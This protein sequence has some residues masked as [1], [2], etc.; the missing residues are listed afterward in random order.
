MRR[1]VSKSPHFTTRVALGLLRKPVTAA[2]Y[3]P[4]SI[5]VLMPH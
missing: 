2:V 4:T 5:A 1:G 3:A